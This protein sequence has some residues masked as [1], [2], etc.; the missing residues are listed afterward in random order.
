MAELAAKS[1]LRGRGGPC[2]PVRL[3]TVDVTLYLQSIFDR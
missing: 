3:A 2:V 1:R